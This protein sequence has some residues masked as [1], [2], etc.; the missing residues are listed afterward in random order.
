M[1][2]IV[3]LSSNLVVL[4]VKNLQTFSGKLLTHVMFGFTG[5]TRIFD[6][7]CNEETAKAHG[8]R[9]QAW[10]QHR[11]DFPVSAVNRAMHSR[12]NAQEQ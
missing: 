2:F 8:R 5:L 12:L 9:F 10:A 7:D 3:L 1:L 4:K 11:C 6:T